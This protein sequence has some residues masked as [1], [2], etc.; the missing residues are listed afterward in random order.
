MVELVL[1]NAGN[2]V[3]GGE[4]A[5]QETDAAATANA[6]RN[7]GGVKAPTAPFGV[8]TL[9]LAIL[10]QVRSH[11]VLTTTPLA[12]RSIDLLEYVGF[13]TASRQLAAFSINTAC[14]ANSIPTLDV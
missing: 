2:V 1:A 13:L 9:Q 8:L 12:G 6:L 10:F 14:T 5:G 7:R 4:R 11:N 3:E